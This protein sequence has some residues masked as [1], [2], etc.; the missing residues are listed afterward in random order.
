M[1]GGAHVPCRR[2]NL[3]SQDPALPFF[4]GLFSVF[5]KGGCHAP[6]SRENARRPQQI[7]AITEDDSI[8]ARAGFY[9]VGAAGAG[10]GDGV[11]FSKGEKTS[12]N[13]CAF[14]P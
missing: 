6:A 7:P 14:F 12:P 2:W 10:S 9:P 5:G 4:I 11:L 1:W 13:P 8:L 3:L